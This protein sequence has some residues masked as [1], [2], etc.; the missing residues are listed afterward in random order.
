MN[1]LT[2]DD[3]IALMD[4]PQGICISMYMSTHRAGIESSQ[5]R[6]KLKNLLKIAHEQL[7]AKGIR[8]PE[9]ETMLQPVQ[10]LL[11][12][13]VFWEYQST[14]LALFLGPDLFRYYHL[15]LDLEELVVVN[16]RFHLKPVLP[17]LSGGGKFYIL[18]LSRHQIRVLQCTRDSVNELEVPGVPQSLAQAM[19]Y[20]DPE[21]QLQFHTQ[22]P[23]RNTGERAALF[24]GHGVGVDD[25]KIN[26]LRYF[27]LVDG[28]LRD[29]LHDGRAPVV[30]A[31]VEYLFPLYREANT[32]AFLLE[33][34]IPG[35]A[36]KQ[37][38]K[39][40]HKQAWPLVEAVFQQ[41]QKE[42]LEH[43]QPLAG[44]GRTSHDVRQLVAAA[45]NGQV[46]TLFVADKGQQWGTYDYDNNAIDLHPE[47][48]PGD[49]DLL[50]LTAIKTLINGGTVYVVDHKDVPEGA[51]LAGM[52]RY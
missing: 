4:E 13:T 48:E 14:G 1:P 12:D 41:K 5:G 26:L 36:D 8:N 37:S 35:N 30:L 18:A 16:D 19:Q 21:R 33:E 47:P 51:L 15:P 44:L 9:I 2:P 23:D 52:L 31:G 10:E 24:H 25:E 20:D 49:E 28:G 22:T 39:E 43:Y 45:C 42:A 6:I 27:H 32:Y 50:D 38:P 7:R 29:L 17:I 46:E 11:R 34:G 3:V 40:L